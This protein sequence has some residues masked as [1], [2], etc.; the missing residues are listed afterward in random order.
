MSNIT[1]L[2]TGASSGIGLELAKL[3]A[4]DGYDL[5]LVARSI[6]RL[7]DLSIEVSRKYKITATVIPKD[8][9]LPDAAEELVETL[10][11]KNIR[12]S[13]L[14][15]NAGVGYLGNSL[16]LPRIQQQDMIQINIT[17]LT[18]LTDLLLPQIIENKGGILNV[19]SISAFQPGPKM[20]IYYASKAY[21]LFYSEG[22]AEELL[23]KNVTIS[24]LC[25]GATATEFESR[26]GADGSRL[27]KYGAMPASKV[28]KIGFKGYKKKKLIVIPGVKNKLLVFSVRTSPRF[29]VR[30]ITKWL[31][32]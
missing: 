7:E 21:V 6:D 14:V 17:A 25:P 3:F 11:N 15:N 13:A 23:D 2:I 18:K 16:T 31:H 5:V 9:S 22:L 28:A 12:I 20:S 29:L 10:K 26:A 1:A 24:C 32:G 30:K 19:A 27:F 8:L 4:T